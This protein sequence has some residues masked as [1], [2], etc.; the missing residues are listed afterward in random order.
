MITTF[1]WEVLTKNEKG[2]PTLERLV[3]DSGWLYRTTE[4]VPDYCTIIAQQVT[5]VPAVRE[6][7]VGVRDEF[8][9]L[10]ISQETEA[11]RLQ[12]IEIE[13]YIKSMNWVRD[14]EG[15]LCDR[16]GKRMV[17]YQPT[18]D[19]NDFDVDNWKARDIG[20]LYATEEDAITAHK[21]V[22]EGKA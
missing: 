15:D 21:L 6:Q 1:V 18:V 11:D 12:V 10:A 19:A 17:W 20:G 16:S 2:Y 4:L 13:K 22:S 7:S 3:V 8:V 14:E 5:F 9:D